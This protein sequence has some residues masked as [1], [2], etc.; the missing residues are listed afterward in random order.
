M[1]KTLFLFAASILVLS[2]IGKLSAQNIWERKEK[3]LK[4]QTW[5]KEVKYVRAG[6][7]ILT[8]DNKYGYYGY[9]DWIIKPNKYTKIEPVFISE[10][11]FGSPDYY[12]VFINNQLGLCDDYGSEIV[13]PGRYTKIGNRTR[14]RYLVWRGS[15]VGIIDAK[16]KE[17]IPPQKYTNIEILTNNIFVIYSGK[18]AGVCDSNGVEIIKPTQYS[19]IQYDSD[20][21][22]YVV[23][24]EGNAGICKANGKEI[25]H[26]SEYSDMDYSRELDMY[27]VKKGS[28]W[29]VLNNQFDVVV[30]PNYTKAL[31]DKADNYFEV[32]DGD[33]VGIYKNGKEIISPS[34][35]TSIG[36]DSKNQYY[37]VHINDEDGICL[38]SGVEIIAPQYSY[39]DFDTAN[40]VFI[41]KKGESFKGE[42]YGVI[43]MEGKIIANVDY[44]WIT[45]G[46]EN[47]LIAWKNE[48]CGGL[49]ALDGQIIIPFEYDDIGQF[50]DGVASVSKGG[51]TYLISNPLTSIASNNGMVGKKGRA[52]SSYHNPDSDVDMNI[53]SG[54]KTDVNTHAFIMAN[55]NYP[56]AKVPYALNDGWAFEKYCKQTL[57]IKE[58]NVQLFEDAT[59]GNIMACV[60][61]MKQ[62]AKAAGGNATLIFYYAGHAFPD[63]EKSTAYLLPVDGDSKNPATGYSL[64]KLYK[65]L[66]SVQTK[67]VICFLDAC[68]SGATRDDQMLIA[69]R[70]VAIKVKDEIPQGNM[71]VM[72]SAS[73]A[74]T[75]HSYEE[76]HHGLFTY[77]LL[78]KLQETNGDVTL[79][80][81]SEYVTKM[82]KRKSVLINQK[83][84]TP[85][86]IPSPKLQT[87]W[88]DIRL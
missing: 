55:E 13:F 63:E 42:K 24:I 45:A 22:L 61:Q 16:G 47:V 3:Q 84:Q 1:S 59:G 8:Y 23:F 77:Y 37:R 49:S 51:Q 62:V 10:S 9:D 81:L 78:H 72:T 35:Y 14:S 46:G 67:Q 19:K 74:E 12:Y 43:N 44:N 76:M 56:E 38:S 6:Y 20:G 87:T 48:K 88:K 70:G 71:V 40:R 30:P 17:L 80:E 85:T 26:P 4:N 25:Y 32:Y 29:G 39:I 73:G 27:W 66:N 41:V 5:A 68:F 52:I 79:G 69:G 33:R 54:K 75:A 18:F 28:N 34:K 60:E 58:E 64:E 11:S 31:Y 50:K 21:N 53:P 7:L 2:S 65:E 15:N 57:G 82:V 83:K 36:F 86:V